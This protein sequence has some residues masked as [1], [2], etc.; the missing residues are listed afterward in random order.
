MIWEASQDCLVQSFLALIHPLPYRMFLSFN[1]FY[2]LLL[3]CQYN[4]NAYIEH[5]I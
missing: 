2:L 5:P 4:E 3:S 1:F